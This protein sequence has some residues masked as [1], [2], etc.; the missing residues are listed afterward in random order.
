MNADKASVLIGVD[1]RSS[2]ANWFSG[3]FNKL[4]LLLG[5]VT[6]HA[7]RQLRIDRYNRSESEA[8]VGD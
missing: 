4:L 1:L 8:I 6:R 2:A 3:F 5:V 7:G